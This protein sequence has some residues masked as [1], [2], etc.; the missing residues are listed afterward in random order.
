MPITRRTALLASALALTIRRRAEAAE[1]I[2]FGE[3]APASGPNAEQGRLLVNGARLA[4]ETINGKAG[5][6]GRQFELLTED[7]QTTN[8]GAVLAFS[9]AAARPDIV[10][11]L[12]PP[13]STQTHAIAADVLKAGRPLILIGSDPALT[14]LGNPWLFRCRANDLYSARVI[15]DYG[16]NDLKK[17]QWAIVHSTDA[18]G[19]AAVKSL[20]SALDKLGIKPVLV[21]GYTN[22]QADF[23]P[24]VLAIKQS[25]ADLI[26]S[27]TTFPTDVALLARQLRQLGVTT[28]WIGSQSIAT[29]TS[30]KLAGP[31]LFGTYGVVDYHPDAN[32]EARAFADHY[33]QVYNADADAFSSWPFDTIMIYAHAINA[34]GTTEP[35]SLRKSILAI[36]GLKGVNGVFNFDSYGESLRGLNVVRNDDGKL[37]FIRHIEFPD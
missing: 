32:P 33:K 25:N 6:L 36:R 20:T 31:A 11:F 22:N 4:V 28:P 27:Y 17:Q 34:A 14:H 7:D 26:A 12:G 8:P 23:T 15:A 5:V 30:M 35:E 1:T 10:A 21:Q 37:T 24:L 19:S 18:F 29:T 16:V 9:R 13:S 3:I 2:K